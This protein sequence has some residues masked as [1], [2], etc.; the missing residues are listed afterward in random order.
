V[1]SVGAG[2]CQLPAA[3]S[4]TDAVAPQHHVVAK[5]KKARE[6]AARVDG[7]AFDPD[8]IVKLEKIE[9]PNPPLHADIPPFGLPLKG[10]CKVGAIVREDEL[11]VIHRLGII[12]ITDKIKCWLTTGLE[13]HQP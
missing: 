13:W 12:D 6:F 2:C 5:D 11:A 8:P 3:G 9:K 7:E 1:K 10:L 4:R